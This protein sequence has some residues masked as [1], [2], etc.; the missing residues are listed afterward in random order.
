MDAVGRK[1]YRL[2]STESW[3]W[4]VVSILTCIVTREYV[5]QIYIFQPTGTIRLI[6][7][8]SGMIGSLVSSL[9][10]SCDALHFPSNPTNRYFPNRTSGC[11]FTIAIDLVHASIFSGI[12]VLKA[13]PLGG[14]F[15][16]PESL[17]N[18]ASQS[19]AADRIISALSS[20]R[21]EIV[22]V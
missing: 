4:F 8:P 5:E 19:L 14:L 3:L 9:V 11:K 1:I 15:H 6:P 17:S 16:C 13:I 2:S 18:N 22:H 21:G 20:L 7:G 10:S 12:Q